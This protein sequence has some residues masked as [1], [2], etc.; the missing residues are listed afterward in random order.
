MFSSIYY[1]IFFTNDKW[2]KRWLYSTNHKDIGTLY[3]IF[4]FLMGLVGTFFSAIIRVQLM[5]PGSLFLGGNFHYYNTVITA[6]ALIIIFFIVIPV[7]IGG[8]GTC[9]SS[10]TFAQLYYVVLER[11]CSNKTQINDFHSS[12]PW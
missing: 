5:Y 7:L 10:I 12:N 9:K 4:G 1:N 8:F 3:I 6:H 11:H 2:V